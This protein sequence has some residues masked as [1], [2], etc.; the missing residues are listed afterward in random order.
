MSI[1][2][3]AFSFLSNCMVSTFVTMHWSV[4]IVH[5][6]HKIYVELNLLIAQS[7]RY[8]QSL[9][10]LFVFFFVL[11][12]YRK[13]KTYKLCI[14]HN[15]FS[16]HVCKWLIITH[17]LKLT[18]KLLDFLRLLE[19]SSSLFISFQFPMNQTWIKIGKPIGS[20]LKI[21][22][23]RDLTNVTTSIGNSDTQKI[24]DIFFLSYFSLVYTDLSTYVEV[25]KLNT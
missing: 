3:L 2:M 23:P 25:E 19:S 1:C 18:C 6:I 4:I 11:Q 20:G 22:F 15:I 8:L 12:I 17:V 7:L 5:F 13:H 9:I 16:Y 21:P 10:L 24:S 14:K